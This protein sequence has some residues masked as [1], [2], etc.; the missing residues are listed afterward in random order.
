MPT[1][2]QP[3]R[4]R[5]ATA[6]I[7]R[8]LGA[9]VAPEVV[10]HIMSGG[11]VP[12]RSGVRLPVTVLF[13]DLRGFTR[14]AGAV[15]PERVV[16]ML[17]EHFDLA[18]AA[19][20]SHGATIDKLVGDALMLTFGTSA[21]DG[22]ESTRALYCA[23]AMHRAFAPLPRRWQRAYG[24]LRVGLAIGVAAGEAVLANVGSAAR[25]DYTLIGS[26]VNLAA[27]LTAAARAGETLASASVRRAVPTPGDGIAFGPARRLR[28]KGIAGP[29]SAYPC[30]F[31]AA[32]AGRRPATVADPV[33]GMKLA[34]EDALLL[35]LSGRQYFFCSTRCRRRFERMR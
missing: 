31:A 27:R 26:V 30:R 16:A 20:L 11:R 14:L 21:G 28:L 34:R 17:D 18:S 7:T 8:Q 33:C 3:A 1:T 22:A 32:R 29:V 15:A 13:A 4:S 9:Y 5:R 10:A 23:A 35:T 24:A 6:R 19:A 25:M 12:L 2:V